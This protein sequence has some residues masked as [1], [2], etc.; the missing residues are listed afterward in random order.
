MRQGLQEAT[1]ALQEAATRDADPTATP[2]SVTDA[3][4]E[5]LDFGATK[6]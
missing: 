5:D 1:R 6:H 4:L 3:A 2:A